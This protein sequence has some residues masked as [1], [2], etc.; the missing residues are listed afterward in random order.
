MLQGRVDMRVGA[1]RGGATEQFLRNSRLP[2]VQRV[3]QSMERM[4]STMVTSVEEGVSR[5]R[6]APSRN[7]YAFVMESAMAN[8]F[9]R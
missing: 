3:W 1:L 9:T 2:A 7:E 8:F 6:S 4:S 5:V